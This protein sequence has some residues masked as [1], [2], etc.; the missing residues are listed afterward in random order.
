MPAPQRILIVD[1]NAS[2]RYLLVWALQ[3]KFPRCALVECENADAAATH[4]AGEPDAVIAHR[5]LGLSNIELV[6]LLRVANRGVPIVAISGRDLSD[7]AIAAGAT[8]FLYYDDWKLAGTIVAAAIEEVSA[9]TA[10]RA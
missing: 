8:R 4:A 1:E 7:D 9:A 5:V 10:R 3:R 2:G 6:K